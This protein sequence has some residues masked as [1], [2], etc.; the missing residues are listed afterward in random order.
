MGEE[1]LICPICHGTKA[2]I[3]DS[4]VTLVGKVENSEFQTGPITVLKCTRC[5]Y[6]MFFDSVTEFA[7]KE[8]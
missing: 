5:K 7:A 2:E 8:F 6:F 1:R 3:V 4:N